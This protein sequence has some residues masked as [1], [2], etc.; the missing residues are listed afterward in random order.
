M[1]NL[2]TQMEIDTKD[3][4]IKITL[5]VKGFIVILME[6]IMRDNF[7][8]EFSM[9]WESTIMLEAVIIKDNGA[10]VPK[11]ESDCWK[12]SEI[13]TEV[14]GAIIQK[15][16]MENILG[17]TEISMWDVLFQIKYKE[18]EPFNGERVRNYVVG[19]KITNSMV[20]LVILLKETPMSWRF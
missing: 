19:G 11:K 3:N 1:G 15:W 20:I 17:K 8:K 2:S 18:K 16:E 6:I 12:V 5:M 13:F 4:L 7:V 10:M 14:N 9:E